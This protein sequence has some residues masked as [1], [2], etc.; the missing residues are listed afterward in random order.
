[1]KSLPNNTRTFLT[2]AC[3]ASVP[4]CPSSLLAEAEPSP[5]VHKD[6]AAPQRERI[7]IGAIRWDA[8]FDDAVNPFD[9]T[10]RFL[11]LE[12]VL[13]AA[14]PLCRDAGRCRWEVITCGV[15]MQ[16]DWRPSKSCDGS[17]LRRL[18]SSPNWNDWPI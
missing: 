11:L 2:L 7:T 8:W 10:A 16:N 1:M 14:W 17:D 13:Q 9:T 15:T 18:R 6:V 5:A 12:S 3:M 4:L